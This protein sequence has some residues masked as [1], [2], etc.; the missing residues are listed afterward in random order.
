MRIPTHWRRLQI[1][2]H[3]QQTPSRMRAVLYAR[4]VLALPGTRAMTVP[5]AHIVVQ[6]HTRPPQVLEYAYLVMQ[7]PTRPKHR[8]IVLHVQPTPSLLRKVLSVLAW[9]GTTLHLMVWRA[10]LVR[11][12][13]T[14]PPPE[15]EYAYLVVQAHTRP[16]QGLEYAYLVMQIP[17]HPKHLQIVP[18]VQTTPSRRRAVLHVL[19]LPGTRL[20]LTVWRAHRVRQAHTRPPPALE[21]A[22]LVV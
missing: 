12:V 22:Y 8:Q 21:H 11:Q 20:H 19:A 18:H 5:R 7:I 10:H 9:P 15:L 1:V 16:P 6:A 17:T 13:H 4:T 2:L 14:R 3:V